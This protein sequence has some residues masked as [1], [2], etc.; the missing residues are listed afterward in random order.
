MG[1]QPST[2]ASYRLRNEAGKGVLVRPSYRVEQEIVCHI[3]LIVMFAKQD[4]N[5][6]A[7]CF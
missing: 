6:I 1:E 7:C 5:S 3:T 2:L 4:V